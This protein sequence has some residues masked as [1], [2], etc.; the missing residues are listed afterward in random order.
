MD[1]STTSPGMVRVAIAVIR[2]QNHLLIC[3]RKPDTVLADFWEFPGGKMLPGESADQ[4]A[5]RETWE[6]LGVQIQPNYSL[7]P[8]Q[9]TYPHAVVHLTPVIC[10]YV[11]GQPRA[12]GCSEFRWI[13]PTELREYPFPPANA[14]LLKYLTEHEWLHPKG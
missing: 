12:I 5:V 6:E 3:R 2:K 8:L 1:N 11:S 9:H 10:T 7:D 13:L 14:A 4:C